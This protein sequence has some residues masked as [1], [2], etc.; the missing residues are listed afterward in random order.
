MSGIVNMTSTSDYDDDTDPPET[1]Y[2]STVDTAV[3][4]G[5]LTLLAMLVAYIYGYYG[6][7]VTRRRILG[8]YVII[9]L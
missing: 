3:F 7:F 2:S 1:L 4:A 8:T 9:T 6:F 5:R